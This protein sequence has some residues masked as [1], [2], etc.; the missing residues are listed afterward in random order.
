MI[1]FQ[2]Y[3]DDYFYE[4]EKLVLSSYAYSIPLWGLS[5]HE[6]CRALHPDFKACHKVW[7][8]SMGLYFI[9]DT[10][11]AAV[12]SEGGYEGDAFFLFDGIERTKDKAL[13]KRMLRFAIMHLSCVDE[14]RTTRSLFLY[15]PNWQAELTAV[16]IEMGFQKQD[17]M[18]KVNILPIGEQPFEVKLPEGFTFAKETVPAFYLSNVHRNAFQY[19]LPTA[20]QGSTAFG[21]LR[22]MRHYDADLEVVVLD[23]EGRPAGFAIG[24]MDEKMPYAELEP[25]AVTWWNRRKGLGRVLITE[26]ANR[27]KA[28]YPQVQGI[29]GGNQP[30]YYALGYQTAVAVSQYKFTRDIHATWDPASMNDDYTL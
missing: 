5:R 4:I 3:T 26:L 13:L 17:W 2:Y 1:R 29:T 20:E 28:K 25:L 11:V 21:K 24:W 18:E 6:F 9:E 19:G 15:I 7:E 30:F 10:L 12:M 8:E 23:E 14:K 27:L 16:A 22:T